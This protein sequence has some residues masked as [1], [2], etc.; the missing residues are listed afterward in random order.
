[1][2][3]KV[4]VLPEAPANKW[5]TGLRVHVHGLIENKLVFVFLS[6]RIYPPSL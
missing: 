1:M 3:Q 4:L 5:D 2:E 6:N